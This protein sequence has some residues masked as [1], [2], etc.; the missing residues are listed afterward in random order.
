MILFRGTSYFSGSIL[1]LSIFALGIQSAVAV[2][3][4]IKDATVDTGWSVDCP[5]AKVQ[6]TGNANYDKT[7]TGGA[8]AN[9][10]TLT[11]DIT[12][13]LNVR[14]VDIKFIES[15]AEQALDPTTDRRFGL[16][17]TLKENITNNSGSDWTEFKEFLDQGNVPVLQSDDKTKPNFYDLVSDGHPGF[18]HF[19]DDTGVFTPFKAL[20]DFDAAA[21]LILGDGTGPF[22]NGDTNNWTGLGIHQFE[23]KNQDRSFTL[24]KLVPEPATLFLLVVG[25]AAAAALGRRRHREAS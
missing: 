17:I 21:S 24:I 2:P 25:L 23:L 10:G 15:A 16:R 4:A 3:V 5:C 12:F 8:K 6:F 22:K 19:H 13:P 20:N 11:L 9:E 1:L 18:A 7:A 14:R